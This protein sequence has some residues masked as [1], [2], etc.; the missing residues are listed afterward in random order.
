[1]NPFNQLSRIIFYQPGIKS[2]AVESR[3]CDTSAR[4]SSNPQCGGGNACWQFSGVRLAR[5][6]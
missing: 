4:M 6:A 3:D 2:Q 5:D 1:M